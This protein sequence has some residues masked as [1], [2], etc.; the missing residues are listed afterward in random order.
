MSIC[1][2]RNTRHFINDTNW[3]L[4]G[5]SRCFEYWISRYRNHLWSLPWNY[6]V[7]YN[8]ICLCDVGER[9]QV[10]GPLGYSYLK[11]SL[12]CFQN[13]SR[14]LNIV[15]LLTTFSSPEVDLTEPSPIIP[16]GTSGEPKVTNKQYWQNRWGR[17]VKRTLFLFSL[18]YLFSRQ[19]QT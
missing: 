6:R 8:N 3:K 17:Y 10:F 9:S 12:K 13:Y 14:D 16:P 15:G 4:R 1:C 5:Y 2:F 18:L 7:L 19:I 11:H